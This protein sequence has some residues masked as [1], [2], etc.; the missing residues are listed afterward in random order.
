MQ[1]IRDEENGRDEI[2][3]IVDELFKIKDE[4]ASYHNKVLVNSNNLI[5]SIFRE[6]LGIEKS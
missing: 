5:I 4:L 6:Q 1:P 2:E 3:L